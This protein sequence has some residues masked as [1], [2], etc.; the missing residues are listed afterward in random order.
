MNK[1]LEKID[2]FI[3]KMNY[4]KNIH[5]LGT[6]FYGSSLTGFNNINSDIDLHIIF[7]NNNQEHIYR[8]ICNI[9]GIKIEY[10]EKCIN[11]LY[12]SVDNDIKER[13]GS[14]YSIL[15][16]SKIIEDPKG[17][18][19]KLQE[20]TLKA[21]QSGFPKMDEEDIIENIAIINNRI[22]KLRI[23]CI[24]DNPSFYSLYY[25]TIE[26]IRR[27]YH[28]IN[29][30]PKINTSKIYRVY[31]DDEYRKTYF[32]GSFVSEKF[33]NMYFNL[34]EN[35]SRDKKE[36][37]NFIEEFYHYV[38]NGRHLSKNEYKIKIKSRNKK[39]KVNN[40]GNK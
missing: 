18:L 9:D 31:K 5:Y 34:I 38:R 16:T 36:L 13:N 23:L 7:D 33:K 30:F 39:S 19:R 37:L 3:K 8:G 12:L 15:G 4:R 27:F 35:T 40:I 10:F 22:E 32:P 17:E 28:S 14:W 11:D 1:N 2:K 26:K 21:Y 6:Y 24:N 29:G 20:Y 25:I